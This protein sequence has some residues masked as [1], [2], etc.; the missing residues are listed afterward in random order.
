MTDPEGLVLKAHKKYQHKDKHPWW[1][2]V[3]FWWHGGLENALEEAMDLLKLAAVGFK[4]VQQWTRAGAVYCECAQLYL[5]QYQQDASLLHLIGAAD[6]HAMAADMAR[7]S[8]AGDI[9]TQGAGTQQ[10]VASDLADAAVEYE[11]QLQQAAQL[12]ER[13]ACY[14]RAANIYYQLGNYVKTYA[15]ALQYHTEAVRLAEMDDFVP[16]L[17]KAQVAL[18]ELAIQAAKYDD[19]HAAYDRLITLFKDQTTYQ[20][21]V[22]S[23]CFTSILCLLC[24]ND[25]VGAETKL[26]QYTARFAKFQHSRDYRCARDLIVAVQNLDNTAFMDITTAFVVLDTTPV[27]ALFAAIKGHVMS[28]GLC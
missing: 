18:A 6:M 28:D 27:A 24:I 9:I 21:Q 15:A 8:A 17:R 14:N 3:A 1:A 19:A 4:N 25:V 16:M 12:F 13:A 20:W 7:R 10:T 2:P 5:N 22:T 23:Y 11:A 26:E